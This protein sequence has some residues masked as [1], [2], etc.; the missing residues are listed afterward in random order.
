[1]SFKIKRNIQNQRTQRPSVDHVEHAAGGSH[2]HVDTSTKLPQVFTNVGATNT[3]VTLGVHVVTESQ[4]DL[5]CGLDR[6][7][8]VRSR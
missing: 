1:M 2:D 6:T 8:Q 7:K 4:Y 5:K 3:S